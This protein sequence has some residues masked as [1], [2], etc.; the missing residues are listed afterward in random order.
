MLG[1]LATPLCVKLELQPGCLNAPCSVASAPA[2]SPG[3]TH[4]P[5][6]PADSSHFRARG[7]P[8]GQFAPPTFQ[9]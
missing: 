3:N 6:M 7:R 1:V 5:L 8:N 2:A 4:Q 9:A